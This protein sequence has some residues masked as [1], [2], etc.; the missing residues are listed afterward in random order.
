VRV[1]EAL[2][3][4]RTKRCAALLLGGDRRAALG[5]LEQPVLDARGEAQPH[6]LK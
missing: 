4:L 6:L 5:L 2:V 3:E 1:E